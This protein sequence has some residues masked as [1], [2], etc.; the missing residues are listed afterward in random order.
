MTDQR[1]MLHNIL[2]HL[3]RETDNAISAADEFLSYKDLNKSL[4]AAGQAE[5]LITARKIIMQHME[6]VGNG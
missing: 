6:T 4:K 3:T 2:T 1:E 5:G